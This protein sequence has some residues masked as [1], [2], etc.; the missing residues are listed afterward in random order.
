MRIEA[1]ANWIR[2]HRQQELE[3]LVSNPK[4]EII[5]GNLYTS[6]SWNRI[7]EKIQNETD[8]FDLIA[9]R[10]QGPFGHFASKQTETIQDVIET[11]SNSKEELFVMLLERTLKLLSPD[12]GILLTQVPVMGTK[13]KIAAAFWKEYLERKHAEGYE[14][15]FESDHH[16]MGDSMAVI[17]RRI[18]P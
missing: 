14:F 3:D 2:A 11:D 12:G 18:S 5:E 10:P 15:I 8:G 9:C 17:R 4:R 13:P 6:K 16:E 7:K 1:E